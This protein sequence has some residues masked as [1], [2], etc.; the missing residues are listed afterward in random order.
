MP[1]IARKLTP[2]EMRYAMEVFGADLDYRKVVVHNKRAYF[3]QPDGIAMTPDGEVYFPPVSYKPDFST[4]ISDAAWLIHELT[5]S[6]QHQKAMWVRT[7]GVLNRNYH[8]GDLAAAGRSF[9][10]YGIEQQASIV[11][12]YFRLLHGASATRGQ[13]AMSDYRRI[14]PFVREAGR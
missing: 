13:G 12:D 7:R 10:S 9:L 4:S 1:N 6:W 5:H 11:A 14:I 3:F 2:G 8:Y